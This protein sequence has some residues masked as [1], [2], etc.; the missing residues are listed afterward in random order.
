MTPTS[1]RDRIPWY[2]Y[3]LFAAVLAITGYYA[4]N[5]LRSIEEGWE[6]ASPALPAYL[7]FPMWG[8]IMEGA[9]RTGGWAIFIIFGV[10]SFY[11]VF[12]ESS[13][14]PA[15]FSG[16]EQ[17]LLSTAR[18]HLLSEESVLGIPMNVFGTLIIGFII[19]GV[20]LQSTGGGKFFINLAFAML[21][22]VRGG[23]AKVAIVASGLFGSLSG[24]VITNVLT[25]G[26][27][28]IPA[29]KRT[30][31]PARYAGGI[32]ARINRGGVSCPRHGATAFVMAPFLDILY[33]GRGCG[34]RTVVPVLLRPLCADR[35]LCR[36]LSAS[37]GLLKEEPLNVK[38]TL[39]EGWYYVFAFFL[40]ID[41]C[42][43]RQG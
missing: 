9:R 8:L 30:G 32:E 39:K 2:D 40:L 13:F 37:R 3:I 35:R 19:F 26:A 41:A 34:D 17:D 43:S 18:Y 23:P 14:V 20:T 27:M 5:G 12:A 7:A 11:P 22:G 25:T 42:L 33:P 24:S 31:Y 28:T 36:T 29:M 10:L 4:W 1:S 38:Q 15:L 16:K 6:Y 21:G